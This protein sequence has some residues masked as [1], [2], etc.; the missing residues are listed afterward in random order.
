MGDMNMNQQEL[1]AFEHFA[2]NIGD[3]VAFVSDAPH[4]SEGVIVERW[5][6]ETTGG[7][8]R[9]YCV[10]F[11]GEPRFVNELEIQASAKPIRT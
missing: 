5:L 2:F 8:N 4:G 11:R 6:I 3:M 7:I 9:R 10:S 1:A